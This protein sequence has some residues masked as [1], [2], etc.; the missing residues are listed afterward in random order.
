MITATEI[1]A[2]E[3]SDGRF[4]LLG[5]IGAQPAEDHQGNRGW[6]E[7]V[8]KI[9]EGKDTPSLHKQISEAANYRTI[10]KLHGSPRNWRLNPLKWDQAVTMIALGASLEFRIA[11][12][13]QKLGLAAM[14]AARGNTAGPDR[15]YTDKE[16]ANMAICGMCGKPNVDNTLKKCSRCKV[17]YYCSVTCQKAKW[18]QH[19]D[20]CKTLRDEDTM[21]AR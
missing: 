4:E 19:K 20:Y 7:I 6:Q 21:Y 16:D 13:V 8:T 10:Y 5:G 3:A 2:P 12:K 14:M 9:L 15:G 17:T 11:P 1:R 18:P